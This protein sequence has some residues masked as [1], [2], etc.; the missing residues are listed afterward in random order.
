VISLIV[1]QY[2][3]AFLRSKAPNNIK[4]ITPWKT[5]VALQF[6]WLHW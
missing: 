5:I 4:L 6:F 3:I 1:H 2:A